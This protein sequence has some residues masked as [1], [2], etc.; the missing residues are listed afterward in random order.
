MEKAILVVVL[1][2]T[3]AKRRQEQIE[4]RALGRDFCSLHSKP[5]DAA[6]RLL[7]TDL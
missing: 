3:A 4:L 6:I 7:P 1:V 5:A 2:F